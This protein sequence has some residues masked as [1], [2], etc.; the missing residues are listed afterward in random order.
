VINTG[1]AA[2]Y[3]IE[4]TNRGCPISNNFA[5]GQAIPQ[6]KTIN[7]TQTGLGV[8]TGKADIND[9]QPFAVNPGGVPLFYTDNSG[10]VT[11]LGGVGVAGVAGSVAEYAA[12]TASVTAGFP[13]NPAPPGV[14][15]I[16]GISLPFVDQTTAPAG[17][18]SGAVAGTWVVN[19]VG[20]PSGTPEGYLVNPVA[21]P[22]GGLTQSQ[23]SSIISAAV[24]EANL[25]RAVIRLPVGERAKMVISVADMDGAIIGLYRMT[26]ATVF[27]ID[28][29][30]AKSRNVIYF[31]GPN[32]EPSDLPGVPM[33]TA[34]TNRTI[35]FGA[36]PLF[37]PGIDGSGP[38]PFFPLYQFDTAN[39]CTQGQQPANSNQSGI[40]FFPGSEP[41]Y[42]NGTLVG[43]LGV[44]GDGV[45]QDDFVT[46]A[47]G[48]NFQASA[49]I[50]ASQIIINGV[51]LPYQNLPRDPT[52]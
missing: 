25:T 46:A 11:L 14:V 8:I 44:S 16:N 30:V 38:G 50:Q 24:N 15:V 39:P 20:S 23:V 36:Q 40:V 41:L 34:V 51:R 21:G 13:A 7:G 19:P 48:A 12:Y 5:P 49:N 6:S 31:S 2:L 1:N 3:G 26:D 29:A 37:P 4:N 33:G 32:R 47:G 18:Q 22:V 27:S 45:D 43:G 42:I 9:S 10:N 28:V 52:N 35:G 17:V